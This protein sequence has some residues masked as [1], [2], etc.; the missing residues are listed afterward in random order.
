[1]IEAGLAIITV[2]LP[3]LGPVFRLLFS[4]GEAHSYGKSASSQQLNARRHGNRSLELEEWPVPTKSDT[5][6]IERKDSDLV[7]LEYGQ[8]ND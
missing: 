4:R 1:M 7:E 2:S 8:V 5:T 6:S 3:S